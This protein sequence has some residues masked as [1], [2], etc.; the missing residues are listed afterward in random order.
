MSCT[1]TY[2][3]TAADVTAGQIVNTATASSDQ[4]PDDQDT[5]VVPTGTPPPASLTLVKNGILDVGSAPGAIQLVKTGS[6]DLGSDGVSTPGDVISYTFEVTNPGPGTLTNITVSDPLVPVITCP[7]GNPIPSLGVGA[8]ETCTGT[9]AIT[10]ADIDAG[11][12][13]NTADATGLDSGGNP[14]SDQ[15]THSETIPVGG[16]QCTGE[17]FIIQNINAELTEIDQS[18]PG[19][20][21]G[22]DLDDLDISARAHADPE[23]RSVRLHG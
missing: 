9:Y 4:T 7:S 5:E 19:A 1:A 12:R 2:V 21:V 8:T 22:I 3:V 20:F 14:V 6:L 10:Q 11:V 16:F 23:R 18:V 15:D 13:D 17:A